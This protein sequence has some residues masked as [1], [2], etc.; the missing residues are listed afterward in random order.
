MNESL[1]ESDLF[2]ESFIPDH[3]PIELISSWIN[4]FWIQIF[5][6]NNL[7][8]FRNQPESFVHEFIFVCSQIFSINHLF[9]TIKLFWM[10]CSWINYFFW[11]D[12]LFIPESDSSSSQLTVWLVALYC[13][14]WPTFIPCCPQINQDRYNDLRF[15][16][17]SGACSI[18]VD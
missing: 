4:R 2:K 13:L 18:K 3:K 11:S 7:I 12:F 1:F 16:Q 6:K 9:Q 8:Q 15:S 10:I 5:S 17:T 14:N